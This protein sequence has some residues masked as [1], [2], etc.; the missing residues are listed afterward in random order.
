MRLRAGQ[1]SDGTGL[2][3]KLEFYGYVEQ[4]PY[5]PAYTKGFPSLAECAVAI[6]C[7]CFPEMAPLFRF[8][9]ERGRGRGRVPPGAARLKELGTANEPPTFKKKG[10][11]HLHGA[12]PISGRIAR[13]A[14]E[15][16][17]LQDYRQYGTDAAPAGHVKRLN[18]QEGETRIGHEI[19]MQSVL[20]G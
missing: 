2:D 15:C 4:S 18:I 9:S 19:T 13:E 5:L 7:A 20:A 8:T 17:E 6:M 3:P 1:D 14:D 11:T 16:F 12:F 10:G